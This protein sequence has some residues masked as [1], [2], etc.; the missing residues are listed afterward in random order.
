MVKLTLIQLN[1]AELKYYQ[2]MINLNKCTGICNVLSPNIY[3]PNEAKRIN[4]KAF[5]MM[6]NKN[7]A[8]PMA[9]YISC[10]WKCKD[11]SAVCNSNQ[12]WNNKTCEFEYQTYPTCKKDCNLNPNMS[13]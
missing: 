9:E 10:D 6:K 12:K 5:N 4:V 8:E 11:N 1:P 13:S 3:V 2:F 7:K